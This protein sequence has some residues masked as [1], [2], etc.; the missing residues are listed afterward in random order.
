MF[1]LQ[2]NSLS[3]PKSFCYSAKSF[4]H[5]VKSCCC[6]GTFCF[7]TG[8]AVSEC[9]AVL[10]KDNFPC[11]FVS[12]S[13]DGF[14]LYI[15]RRCHL[16]PQGTSSLIFSLI[17]CLLALCLFCPKH[18]SK[19]DNFAKDKPFRHFLIVVLESKRKDI[20]NG[21]CSYQIKQKPKTE[22]SWHWKKISSVDF[23]EIFKNIPGSEQKRT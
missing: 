17:L 8:L 12:F 13:Q 9:F 19:Q 22:Y 6:K 2:K 4:A 14:S 15:G 1:T 7:A 18:P 5:L 10:V 20:I 21:W 23:K 3:H 16:K 11:V